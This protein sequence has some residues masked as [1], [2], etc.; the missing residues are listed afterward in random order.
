MWPKNARELR[1][2]T[3]LLD[4]EQ[5]KIGL[6]SS[7]QW[8]ASSFWPVSAVWNNHEAFVSYCQ[9][10]KNDSTQDKTQRY[11]HEGLQGKK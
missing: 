8:V 6:V 9:E 5:F 2:W 11:T 3:N 4:S 1:M 7:I 10:T